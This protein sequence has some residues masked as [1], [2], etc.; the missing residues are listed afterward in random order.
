MDGL[1]DIGAR[2]GAE[3]MVLRS[4]WSVLSHLFREFQ[5][6]LAATSPTTATPIRVAGPS[7]ILLGRSKATARI[8]AQQEST[9]ALPKPA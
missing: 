5:V 3:Q 1:I 2:L 4:G 7:M 9:S 8:A 6:R